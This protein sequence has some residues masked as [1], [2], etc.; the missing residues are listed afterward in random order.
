[1]M[2]LEDEGAVFLAQTRCA[3]HTM[4]QLLGDM[5]GGKRRGHGSHP[6]PKPQDIDAEYVFTVVRNPYLRCISEFLQLREQ[7]NPWM[8]FSLDDWLDHCTNPC[9]GLGKKWGVP[10]W[11]LFDRYDIDLAIPIEHLESGLRYLPFWPKWAPT[12]RIARIGESTY[13]Q[14]LYVPARQMQRIAKIYHKDFE[15]LGYATDWQLGFDTYKL[16]RLT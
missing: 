1:M 13:P 6:R 15:L 14:N 9:L 3:T 5:F 12:D 2:V 10:Q 11:Q 8:R 4:Y 7:H 16:G